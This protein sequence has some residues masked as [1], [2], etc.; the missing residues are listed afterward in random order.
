MQIPY[1]CS[2]A[3]YNTAG[4]NIE[5]WIKIYKIDYENACLKGNVLRLDLKVDRFVVHLMSR[6][7]EFLNLVAA[8]KS[9]ITGR[10][11]KKSIVKSTEKIITQRRFE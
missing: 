8:N 5:Q 6:G 4:Y 3:L 11:W 10:N 1:T 9:M 2:K 7:R